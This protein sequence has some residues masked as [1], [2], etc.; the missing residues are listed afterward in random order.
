MAGTILDIIAFIG[1]TVLGI[2][3]LVPLDN[4][5]VSSGAQSIVRVC[6]ALYEDI[7][8]FGGDT[9]G[10]TLWNED[11]KRLG[12][13]IPSTEQVEA[14]SFVDIVV[15]INPPNQQPTYLK[16]EGGANSV[17]VAYISHTWPDGT[18]RGWL[19]D[20]GKQCG[21]QWY[22]SDIEVGQANGTEYK[23][24]GSSFKNHPS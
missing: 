20:I 22:Y 6:A 16:I 24:S 1:D 18:K 9:P 7:S 19:G 14:G 23:A 8:D 11:G 5:Q 12:S 17:C 10:I 4:N 3:Q 2:L 21:K 13:T 15:P